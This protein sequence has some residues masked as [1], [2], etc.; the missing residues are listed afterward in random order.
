MKRFEQIE[1]LRGE[2]GVLLRQANEIEEE[3][4]NEVQRPILR[5]AVGKCFKF[6]NSYGGD[7]PKWWLY[8]KIVSFDEKEMTFN[9]VQFEHTSQPKIEVDYVRQYCYN[10]RNR[11]NEGDGWI[12]ISAA[13]YEREAKKLLK[14]VHSLL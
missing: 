11:F 8:A 6:R 14:T 13:E 2:A 10:G 4:R 7:R 3:E 5:K 12:A 1:K 9:T